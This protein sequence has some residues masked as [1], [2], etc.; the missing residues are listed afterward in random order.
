MPLITRV[1]LYR[2]YWLSALWPL[3]HGQIAN[4]RRK[5]HCGITVKQI[6]QQSGFSP[7]S[8]NQKRSTAG[9][10]RPR[11]FVPFDKKQCLTY[12]SICNKALSK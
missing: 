6:A 11:K 4:S 8:M 3:T 9:H 2:Y 1:L 10:H 12:Q 7:T 5:T